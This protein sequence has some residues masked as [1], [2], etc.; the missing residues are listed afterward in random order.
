MLLL[1]LL[2]DFVLLFFSGVLS[3]VAAYGFLRIVLPL[4]PDGVQDYQSLILI[5]ALLSTLAPVP[6]QST[7]NLAPPTR[8]F[9]N[10]PSH[11]SYNQ[12]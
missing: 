9:K 11:H 7:P 8:R 10:Q 6:Q 12:H 1:V 4:F 3:K 2:T 5:L